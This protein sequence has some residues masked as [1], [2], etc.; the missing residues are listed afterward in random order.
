MSQ[1]ET[2]QIKAE[3]SDDNPLGFI[4]INKS[5][6]DQDKQELF[7]E[8][9]AGKPSDGLN[10]DQLKAALTAK[11]IAIPDNAKKAD[12]QALLDAAQ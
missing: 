1:L 6:F 10:V 7:V 2:V 8:G 3:I 11:N 12:L 4:V 9:V 5:D